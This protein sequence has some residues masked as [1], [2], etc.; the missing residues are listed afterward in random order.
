ME[1]DQDV[2]RSLGSSRFGRS[3]GGREVDGVGRVFADHG[4]D[5]LELRDVQQRQLPGGD[6]VRR[7]ANE[8]RAN[9]VPVGDDVGAAH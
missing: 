1:S 7:G 5:G 2:M 8:R 6:D 4:I 9:S 3:A